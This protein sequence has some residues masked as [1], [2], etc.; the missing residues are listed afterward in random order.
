[1]GKLPQLQVMKGWLSIFNYGRKTQYL[2]KVP[3]ERPDVRTN[4]FITN[5]FV[6]YA[7]L[8]LTILRAIKPFLH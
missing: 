3:H 2:I 6:P 5:R 7:L 4:R 1:V 8:W